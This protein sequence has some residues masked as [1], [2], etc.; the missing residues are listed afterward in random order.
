M[1]ERRNSYLLAAGA[2]ALG[3]AARWVVDAAL[4]HERLPFFT[5][6]RLAGTGAAGS[7]VLG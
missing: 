3:I 2:V 6:F 5:F 7:T 1:R 4:Q